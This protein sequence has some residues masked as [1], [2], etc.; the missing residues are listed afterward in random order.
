MKNA[1]IVLGG[2]VIALGWLTLPSEGSLRGGLSARNRAA[3]QAVLT[4]Q[5]KDWN[6]GNV[7][8]FLEGYWRSEE[9]TF[10]GTQGMARGW[11]GVRERYKKSY[12]DQAAMGKLDFSE[13][14]F[15]GLGPDAALV[16]GRWHLTREKGDVGG[17]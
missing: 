10:S 11:N 9:L 6:E 17:V 8:A 12:A 14:E 1:K 13:L 5:Q 3:I 15:R 7:D 2:L 16:L 4:T